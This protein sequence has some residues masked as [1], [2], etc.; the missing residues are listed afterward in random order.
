LAQKPGPTQVRSELV[1][2]V[3]SN[4]EIVPSRSQAMKAETS[5]RMTGAILMLPLS[6]HI[7]VW[8]VLSEPTPRF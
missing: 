7:T 3:L 5:A 4:G 2:H 6:L 1:V 8:W